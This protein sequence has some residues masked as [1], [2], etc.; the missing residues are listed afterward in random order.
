MKKY[1]LIFMFSIFPLGANALDIGA[2]CGKLDMVCGQANLEGESERKCYCQ[3]VQESTTYTCGDGFTFNNETKKCTI[4]EKT[5]L[6][7]NGYAIYKGKNDCD[8]TST[9][10]TQTC[11]TA[12][13]CGEDC[14][15]G[16]KAMECKAGGFTPLG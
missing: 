1:F 5:V 11:Y 10:T 2:P 12:K 3:S 14:G 7:S 8:P 13:T 16:I 15:D 6:I 4:Q 9:T